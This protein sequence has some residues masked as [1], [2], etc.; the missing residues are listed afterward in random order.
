MQPDLHSIVVDAN[1]E[2]IFMRDTPLGELHAQRT[3]IDFPGN[4]DQAGGEHGWRQTEYDL[5]HRYEGTSILIFGR[6]SAEGRKR[7]FLYP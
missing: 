1:G 2:L 5:S 6:R 3:I 4:L 7:W